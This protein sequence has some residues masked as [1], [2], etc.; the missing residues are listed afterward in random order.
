MADLY[1]S[2]FTGEEIDAAINKIQNTNTEELIRIDGTIVTS[3][4]IPFAQGAKN[5]SGALM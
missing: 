4:M 3:S 5:T 1:H 2:K